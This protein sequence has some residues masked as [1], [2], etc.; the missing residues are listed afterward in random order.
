MGNVVKLTSAWQQISD[1]TKSCVI[2]PQRA[3]FGPATVELA[4]EATAPTGAYTGLDASEGANLPATTE[5]LFA[6]GDGSIV[7]TLYTPK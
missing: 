2:V 4:F 5:K 6:R 7:V 1:G 3:G